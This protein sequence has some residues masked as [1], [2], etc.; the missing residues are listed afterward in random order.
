MNT[1][2]LWARLRL[3]FPITWV[4]HSHPTSG[5][6]EGP[7]L[8]RKGLQGLYVGIAVQAVRFVED[9]LAAPT[10]TNVGRAGSSRWRRAVLLSVLGPLSVI[11]V[12]VSGGSLAQ[13]SVHMEHEYGRQVARAQRASSIGAEGFGETVSAYSGATSFMHA[14]I[15]LPGNSG[16]PVTLMRSYRVEDRYGVGRFGGFGDWD[17]AVPYLGGV[18]Q[19]SLGWVVGPASSGD[20][21]KRC[22]LGL[23]PYTSQLHFQLHE[24]WQ[25]TRVSI[26][27][28]EDGLI[29]SANDAYTDPADGQVYPWITEDRAR[30]RCNATTKNGYPGE[31][32]VLLTQEGVTYFFDWG[33][34]LSM[35]SLRKS[36]DKVAGRKQVRLLASRIEDRYG[37][38]VNFT[39]SGTKLTKIESNDGRT[40]MLA[41]SGDRVVSATAHGRQ[42]NYGYDTVG[43]LNSVVL[44]DQSAWEF[45]S[46]GNLGQG[47]GPA[48]LQVDDWEATC[49]EPDPPMKA[50]EYRVKHPAGAMGRFSF[51][52]T[53]HYRSRVPWLCNMSPP[54]DNVVLPGEGPGDE[55]VLSHVPSYDWLDIP[56]YFDDYALVSKEVSGA[57]MVTATTQRAYGWSNPLGFCN[58]LPNSGCMELCLAAQG[59]TTPDGRWVTVTEP[60][61]SQK[62]QL[63]GVQYGINEGRLLRQQVLA[64]SGAVLRDEAYAYV[65]ESE[66][67]SQAF[68]SPLGNAG[69]RDPI[70][71]KVRPQV[72][73]TISQDGSNFIWNVDKACLNGA[74]LVYCFDIH[75]RPTRITK[76]SEVMP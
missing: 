58:R 48:S 55:I 39:Y 8:Y 36:E 17:V 37:N 33:V 51:Q 74:V 65:D 52:Q 18:F 76:A 56:N 1:R 59:C 68:V 24:I 35:R 4:S 50:F 46:T 25:G 29:L 44:P 47:P 9:V 3:T 10:R 20:R 43:A 49:D 13:S 71:G 32:F 72:K 12:F 14:D 40:I 11:S 54:Q 5:G 28:V 75:A 27:G 38:W 64:P 34:E 21:H 30:I 63:L 22:S 16:L 41:Y 69:V 15:D 66:A 61:G 70:V 45:G 60:D 53:R 67:S 62:R 57:G 26:P 2:E 7:H 73:H 23:A 31:S 42:W 6:S 19:G